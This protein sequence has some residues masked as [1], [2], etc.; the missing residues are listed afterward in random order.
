MEYGCVKATIKQ[1][2]QL[3]GGAADMHRLPPATT[4]KHNRNIDNLNQVRNR[5]VAK[6]TKLPQREHDNY[7]ERH[8]IET[9]T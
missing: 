6:T 1:V 9:G 5:L 4:K 2:Y 7:T 8:L 3:A